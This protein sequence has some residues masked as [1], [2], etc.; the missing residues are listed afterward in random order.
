MFRSKS[1][2]DLYSYLK[3]ASGVAN[4]FALPITESAPHIYISMI[5]MMRQDSV[6]A[7]HYSKKMGSL[8]EA[9]R[10]GTKSP[11]Q[12]LKVFEGHTGDI[13]SVNFSPDGKHVVSGS[14]DG[15]V[16]IWDIVTGALVAGPFES[17]GD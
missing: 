3:D 13:Y 9:R 4:A 15:T 1:D 11:P 6:V 10:I 7:Q 16:R 8:V 14:I 12:W 2:A 17:F 5:P